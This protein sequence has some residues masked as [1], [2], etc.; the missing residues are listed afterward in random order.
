M[1]LVLESAFEVPVL[2]AHL[3]SPGLVYNLS[4]P[5]LWDE[6]FLLLSL[7]K[8]SVGLSKSQ[9]QVIDCTPNQALRQGLKGPLPNVL[10]VATVLATALQSQPL[11]VAC[12]GVPAVL[13]TSRGPP[14]QL[15]AG[16]S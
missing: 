7:C 1:E 10:S 8:D 15:C 4:V 11:P 16:L 13:K 2:I 6:V 3:C 9:R 14:Q 12:P 5:C